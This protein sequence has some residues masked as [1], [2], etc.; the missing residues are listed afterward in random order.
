MSAND[1]GR[2][3]EKEARQHAAHDMFQLTKKSFTAGPAFPT[4]Y[5]MKFP[6][7]LA[8]T[9]IFSA[10]S[11][12]ASEIIRVAV[13]DNQSSV[14]IKAAGGLRPEDAVPGKE[15]KRTVFTSALVGSRPVRVLPEGQYIQVNGKSYR[16]LIE[17]RK[18]KNDLLL[19]VNELDIED[20]LR[21]VVASEVPY[22]W[23]FE[24]LK[25]QAVASRTFALYQKRMTRA[26]P[27]HI[28]ASVNG[29]VYDGR[30]SEREQAVKAVKET[31]GVIV[32]Y[33]GEAAAAF[34]H[35]SCGGHT[36]NAMELWGINEPYLQGVNCDCQEISRYGTW[37]KRIGL[38]VISAALERQGYRMKNASN[39]RING[40]TPAGRVKL[41]SIRTSEGNV[42]V[43]AEKFRAALG[44]A[45]IPSVFF[46]AETSGNE[47][48]ISGRGLGHGVGMC[49][50]GA[51]QMAQRGSDF[52]AILA[53]YYPGTTVSKSN[54]KSSR[55]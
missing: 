49:Q 5:K 28:V 51:R 38:P 32:A 54:A 10:A 47:V 20:Y 22:D 11:A 40:I 31:E 55:H 33:K 4:S 29:Q 46:E 42:N 27:Y 17:I 53:H 23:E 19:I 35:S 52:K 48:V 41:V 26:K 25:A 6:L 7:V 2:R 30:N 8:Y 12:S 50:W 16:G 44:Y 3:S 24:A 39:V 9:L 34:Y 21:G 45:S 1:T 13:L 37:E 43:P 14:T 18:K 36:E 15:S